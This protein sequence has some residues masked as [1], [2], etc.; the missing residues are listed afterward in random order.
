MT[1]I[2]TLASVLSAFLV[3]L[4]QPVV[5]KI[6]LPTL[7]GTPAVWS[8]CML[9]FQA[10]LLMG[11]SYAHL[12]TGKL[13]LRVQPIVHLVLLAVVVL[14]FPIAFDGLENVDAVHAPL[15]WLLT[16]LLTS[17]GLPYF[18][19]SATSPL[20]QRWFSCTNH[21][22][23]ANPYFLY[24]ASNIGSMGA[25]L[26][27]PFV[28]EP[29]A[30]LAN[31]VRLWEIGITAL[32]VL[33]LGVAFTLHKNGVAAKTNIEK[34]TQGETTPVLWK[35]RAKWLVL[36]LVP[37][38]LLYGVTTYVTTDIASAPLLWV[39]PL[40]LY[41]TTFILVFA[42]RPRG[43][44]LGNL[45]HLPMV[46]I[47][48]AFMVMGLHSTT[49]GLL[50]HIGGFFVIALSLH[51]ILARSK[52]STEHLTEFFLWMSLGGVVGGIF[53][54]LVAPFVFDSVIEYP[55]MML[56]SILL[57]F[58][59]VDTDKHKERR[60]GPVKI[61]IIGVT[62]LALVAGFILLPSPQQ[63]DGENKSGRVIYQARSIFGVNKVNYNSDVNAHVFTHG[64]TVHGVQPLDADKKLQL[65][66]YYTQMEGIFAVR[67][68]LPIA[69]IGLGAGNLACAGK[70]GQELDM[71][72]IDPLVGKIASNPEFFT[73][74]RD[75][76]T[77]V[78]VI[79]GDGR[80][81]IKQQMDGKYGVIL[82]DAFS[83][84][85]I[86]VHLVTQEALQVY[87]SKLAPDGV[88]AIHI[89]NRYFNLQPV[90]SALK[91][92]L[93]LQGS[94]RIIQKDEDNQLITGSHWIV[95]SRSEATLAD[96]AQRGK[97]WN[98]L[99]EESNP[100]Y[101]WK[102]DFSNIFLSLKMVRRWLGYES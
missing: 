24:A 67:E 59:F 38:S 42:T 3:F 39:L 16:M 46:G 48:M 77:K 74:L 34:K 69:V 49:V 83:S 5:A 14:G 73:Y 32:A 57:H 11:Y 78:R 68:D 37:S 75:C 22:D 28:I 45:L 13:G 26:L 88:L 10:V 33:F 62:A 93:G 72:E 60:Q 98:A 71:Y 6:A 36:S 51:G 23:A 50:F 1:I 96:I 53:N 81:Q 66:S 101:L 54:T 94:Y 84:D 86:P 4:I 17:V 99:P 15:G 44:R 102:D 92:S 63:F 87:L 27:Y 89:S 31:Q 56:L 58:L 21:K 64:T 82:M 55:M 70:S 8:G 43:I 47:L 41:L 85:S 19:I 25:L 90:L 95:L 2:Y 7:G 12:L 20:L 52:P 100:R 9:F 80:Q 35:D 91:A 18:A 97:G 40:V 30:T 76:P 65:L 61:K 79:L 29:F